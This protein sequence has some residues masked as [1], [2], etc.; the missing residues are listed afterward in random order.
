MLLPPPHPQVVFFSFFFSL[1]VFVMRSYSLILVNGVV[2][3][4]GD[5][6]R[7]KIQRYPLRSSAVK[8]NPYNPRASSHFS[9]SAV[10]SNRFF[11]FNCCVGK[12]LKNES[13]SL[14]YGTR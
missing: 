8:S 12:R 13:F 1:N 9:N 3:D 14:I 11:L 5:S 4:T 6:A 2:R 7:P 10:A